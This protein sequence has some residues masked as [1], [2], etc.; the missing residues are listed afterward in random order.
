MDP[1]NPL[2]CSVVIDAPHTVQAT[3][4][5]P[6]LH[7]AVPTISGARGNVQ[8]PLPAGTIDC[9]TPP[10]GGLSGRCDAAFDE[11]STVQLAAVP[12]VPVPCNDGC[13]GFDAWSGAAAAANGCGRDVLTCNVVMHGDQSITAAFRPLEAFSAQID[14]DGTLQVRADWP[15]SNMDCALG[16]EFCFEFI[17]QGRSVTLTAVPAERFVRWETDA[18]HTLTC[19]Q[20]VNPCT[21]T[22]TQETFVRAR[23][24]NLVTLVDLR[25]GT[26]TA[27]L[28]TAPPFVTCTNPADEANHTCSGLAPWDSTIVIS[29]QAADGFSFSRWEF[30][31]ESGA[32]SSEFVTDTGTTATTIRIAP[33]PGDFLS[34]LAS[35]NVHNAQVVFLDGPAAGHP[36]TIDSNSLDTI[37]LAGAGLTPAPAAGNDFVIT[38]N[39]ARS[40]NLQVFGDWTVY[41]RFA[42]IPILNVV[43]QDVSGAATPALL[44]TLAA[45]QSA[46]TAQPAATVATGSVFIA[47]SGVDCRTT[48]RVPLRN[49]MQA[50]LTATPDR[51]SFFAGAGRGSRGLHALERSTARD[52]YGHGARPDKGCSELQ[53]GPVAGS[54]YRRRW[55]RGCRDYASW[56]QLPAHVF[57]DIRR[58]HTGLTLGQPATNHT[59]AG[60]TGALVTPCNASATTR[61]Q[62]CSITLDQS[63]RIGATFDAPPDAP[64]LTVGSTV[65]ATW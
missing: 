31:F 14:G 36:S 21:L 55:P 29:Q 9:F 49:G 38:C 25:A 63:A 46:R 1:V 22:I 59:F 5:R 58:R 27:S 57:G 51:G 39:G 24:S 62:P 65:W 20:T 34:L 53:D 13:S 50:T 32:T 52:V 37:T 3:F 35:F 48:C 60:W 26:T 45:D 44:S 2:Q 16:D 54:H 28:V 40:I 56:D 6:V 11:G 30:A 61:A 15:D 41:A 19:A 43:V 64:L 18:D 33:P 7:V 17:L 23:M 47:G 10:A 12:F 8:S 4:T 42:P